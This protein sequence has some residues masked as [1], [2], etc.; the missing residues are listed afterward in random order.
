MPELYIA[1]FAN[2]TKPTGGTELCFLLG[3]ELDDGAAGAATLL[4]KDQREAPDDAH[5]R[6]SWTN[7]TSIGSPWTSPTGQA[8]DQRQGSHGRRHGEGAEEPGRAVDLLLAAYRPATHGVPAPARPCDLSAG[9]MRL[10]AAG[11]GGRRGVACENTATTWSPTPPKSSRPAVAVVL[12][13]PHEGRARHRLR[14]AAR[15]DRRHGHHRA[16]ALLRDRGQRQGVRHP[17]GPRHPAL[18][19][20]DHGADPV[21][22][23]RDHRHRAGVP[24]LPRSASRSPASSAAMWTCAGKCWPAPPCSPSAW[25]SSPACWPCAASGRSSR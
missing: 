19:N 1:N 16:D 8:E 11:Q 10:A 21:V 9:T 23:G 4:T 25:R 22:L 24:D 17:A 14:G 18:A 6:S 15:A 3:S 13:L 20:L 5:T 12:A 7:R 2:F